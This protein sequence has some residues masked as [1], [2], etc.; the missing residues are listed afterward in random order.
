MGNMCCKAKDDGPE[1]NRLRQ[2]NNNY[3]SASNPNNTSHI[4]I[5]SDNNNNDYNDLYSQ[6]RYVDNNN[7][8]TFNNRNVNITN[9]DTTT[10]TNYRNFNNFNNFNNNNIYNKN[11]ID[12]IMLHISNGVNM[13]DWTFNRN[14]R[15]RVISERIQIAINTQN[16]ILMICD[17]EMLVENEIIR[18]KLKD[19]ALII[20]NDSYFQGGKY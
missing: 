6:N 7:Y 17:A 12:D 15:I 14:D 13:F 8:N 4:D 11:R 18:N 19:D 16:Q 9:Y 1:I 10:P 3:E 2:Q 5:S 20:Y